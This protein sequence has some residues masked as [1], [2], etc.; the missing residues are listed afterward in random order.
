MDS[1]RVQGGIALQGKVRI[2]G[3]KNAALPIMAASL[4]AEGEVTLENVPRI[5]DVYGMLQILEDLGCM[6]RWQRTSVT[7][8]P[9]NVNSGSISGETVTSMRSS[10][11]LLGAMLA[12][13][14]QAILEYPGG[15]VIGKRPIDLHLKAL[16]KMGVAFEERNGFLKAR[17]L[18]GLMPNRIELD[19][20]SVG[21]TENLIMAAT[22]AKGETRIIGA[23]REPEV[24]ALCHFLHAAGIEVDGVGTSELVICGGKPL[25]TIKYSVPAD[26]IVAGT[27]LFAGF[28]TGGSMLLEEA[29]VTHMEAV[30]NVAEK[31]GAAIT[32]S[33]NGLFMQ[34]PER[35]KAF[36]RLETAIYPGFPTDLQSVV[37]AV[38][39]VGKGTTVIRENIFENRFRIVEEL[40][41]MGASIR[42]VDDKTVIVKGV[43][44]LRGSR[45]EARELRGGA[46]LAVAALGAEGETVISGRK[47]IDRGYENIC[48]DLRE[49][50]ARI[51]SE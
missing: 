48:R 21:A 50:G 40:K 33:Q 45:V 13:K 9:Q 38:R 51:V 11:F 17:A 12:K 20:P 35:P 16:A 47:Y 25:G 41:S 4:M 19:F 24:Q 1:I 2:Q 28:A 22:A 8:D 42:T 26:R 44:R 39:C 3:S 30:L 14:G 23:A 34:F 7:I 36:P 18:R 37:L 46:A 43:K 5:A 10:I 32:L 49:L 27:Y 31:M 15:C 6:I 29:P